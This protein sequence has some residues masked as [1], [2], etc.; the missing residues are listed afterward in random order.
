MLTQ[1]EGK[2][3]RE[4]FA[5]YDPTKGS[6][7]LDNPYLNG[8]G[9]EAEALAWWKGFQAARERARLSDRRAA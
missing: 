8:S 6:G 2:L 5:A 9:R 1:A 7:Y 4:G 3:Y